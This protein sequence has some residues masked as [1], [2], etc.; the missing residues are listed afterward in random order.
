MD[1]FLDICN[2][3]D[4]FCIDHIK[5][6]EYK[7]VIDISTSANILK[8]LQRNNLIKNTDYL[9][10]HVEQQDNKHGGNNQRQ[11]KL[12]PSAFKLCLIRAKNSRDYANYYLLLEKVFKYYSDY[13]LRIIT[14]DNHRL[15]IFIFLN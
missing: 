8:C 4:Q 15:Y 11:Y 6:Q 9:L 14:I 5:L 3:E 7:V 13:Q 2:K 12:T 1:Y 10:F